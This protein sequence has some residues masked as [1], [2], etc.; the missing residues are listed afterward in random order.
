MNITK[1]DTL[2]KL[3]TCLH[4]INIMNSD[5]KGRHRCGV[6]KKIYTTSSTEQELE[7]WEY[8]IPEEMDMKDA[9]KYNQLPI[10]KDP[11]DCE[12]VETNHKK[13]KDSRP[14]I[15]QRLMN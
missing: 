8:Q 6:K 4:Q 11:N 5:L 1:V 3:A 15:D 9:F 12:I 7:G 13:T 14:L 10:S 2:K